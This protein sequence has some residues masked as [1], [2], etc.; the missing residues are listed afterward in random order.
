MKFVGN[1]ASNLGGALSINKSHGNAFFRAAYFSHNRAKFGGAVV[2]EIQK[3][4]TFEDIT[5]EDNSGSALWFFNSNVTFTGISKI[6]R[7]TGENG[8]GVSSSIITLAGEEA[9]FDANTAKN[10]GAINLLQ[11]R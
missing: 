6:F 2:A 3:N 7:N 8:G 10:G 9:V 1:S 5:V 4:A 11:L